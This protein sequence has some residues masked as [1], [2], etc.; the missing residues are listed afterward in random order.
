MG[1]W[2]GSVQN[3]L[4]ENRLF[5]DEIKVGTG[6]TEY[7]WS[8][9]EAYEVIAV[10]DQKHFTMRKYDHKHI[11]EAFTNDW[12]LI[13]NPDNPKYE[14]TKRGNYWYFTATWTREEVE[15]EMAK[16]KAIEPDCGEARFFLALALGGFD[17]DTIMEKGKQ[18]KYRKANISIG[19]AD[20]YYDYEF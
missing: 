9:R 14:M 2:Y 12:E 4:E 13:S 15:R 19:K 20:Y 17:Y 7:S 10:K 1:R 11:G 8:D 18:T 3:R 16:A 6:V 5:C